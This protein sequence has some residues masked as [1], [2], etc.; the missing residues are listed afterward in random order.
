MQL[1][2]FRSLWGCRE[3]LGTSYPKDILAAIHKCN[4]YHGIEASLCDLG[5]SDKPC[6]TQFKDW[7]EDHS[8]DLITGLYTSWQ[9]YDPPTSHY[10]LYKPV[11]MHVEQFL[12]QLDV[13][14]E[15]FDPVLINVHAGSDFWT[16]EDASKFFRAVEKPILAIQDSRSVC[17]ETHRSRLFGS[18]FRTYR[19]LQEFPWIRLT[20]DFSHWAVN[21]E[22]VLGTSR[23]TGRL[24][25][26]E[27][28]QTL[29]PVSERRALV[30]FEDKILDRVSAHA[31]HI[32]ARLGSAQRPQLE[33]FTSDHVENAAAID[34]HWKMWHKI[35]SKRKADNSKWMSMTPEYGPYPYSPNKSSSDLWD[36]TNRAADALR[37]EFS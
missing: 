35:W 28:L 33:E 21:A 9:D 4:L 34:G 27:G 23:D 31:F 1:R 14:M 8:F 24:T 15:E 12:K 11:D 10:D 5:G 32:H 26:D 18:P 2:L 30:E 17:F 25:G 20:M 3:S 37:R 16:D 19:T 13:A 7:L 6:R 36:L 22:R 29:V